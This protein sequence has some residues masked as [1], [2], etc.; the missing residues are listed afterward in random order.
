MSTKDDYVAGM[1]AELRLDENKMEGTFG[2]D[3]INA[4]GYEM[5]VQKDTQ[6][7]TLLDRAFV[8]TATGADL[9]ACGADAQLPRKQPTK[10]QVL[11][12]ISG[13]ENQI[14]SD[15]VKIS[16]GSLVFK[17]METKSI[18]AA[19]YINVNFECETAGAVGNIA[20]GTEFNFDGNYYGL[21]SA[22]AVSNGVG[23]SD[24][25][26]DESYRARILF[27]LQ[28]EASS[29]NAAHYKMWAESVEGVATAYVVPLWNGNGTVKVLIS[30]PDKSN[31]TQTLLNEVA[32]YIE[33]QKP[34]GAT[35]TVAAIDYVNINVNAVVTLS[36]AGSI[37]SV[38]AEFNEALAQYLSTYGLTTVS[39]LKIADLLLQCA[40]V[41][42]VQSYTLN[43]GIQSITLTATQMPRVGTTT[44][45]EGA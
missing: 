34:I 17:S 12:K 2:Q 37:S 7:D 3:I 9:D 40:G 13:L 8:S 43:G 45:T 24:L 25:E 20:N 36:N 11:V 21:T 10:S 19:D 44:I 16:Y 33:T 42:D 23:G 29:G 39:Y 30:T 41:S 6:I 31:P 38:T 35:V 27:K 14:V 26:D 5:A 15:S 1:N 18:P 28:I 32:A 22:V 4:V